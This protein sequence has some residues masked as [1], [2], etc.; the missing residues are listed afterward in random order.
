[1]FCE[2]ILD[3]CTLPPVCFDQQP[4]EKTHRLEELHHRFV[5]AAITISQGKRADQAAVKVKRQT[6]V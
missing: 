3:S 2:L 5:V 6:Y 1:M 4:K